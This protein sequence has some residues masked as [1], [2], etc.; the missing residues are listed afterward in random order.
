MAVTENFIVTTF[1]KIV[2]IKK[3][4]IPDNTTEAMHPLSV[5]ILCNT[6]LKKKQKREQLCVILL[7]VHIKRKM[8]VRDINFCYVNGLHYLS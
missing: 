4:Y 7:H 2:Q 8:C 1:F 6:S 3:S 5:N